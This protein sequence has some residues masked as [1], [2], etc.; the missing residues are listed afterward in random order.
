MNGAIAELWANAINAAS[1]NKVTITGTSHQRLLQT[2]ETNSPAIP[3]LRA[4]LRMNF[5]GLVHDC[6]RYRD[7]NCALLYVARQ[8]RQQRNFL[9]G[10]NDSAR[11][12]A[13]QPPRNIVTTPANRTVFRRDQEVSGIGPSRPIDQLI[14]FNASSIQE[15]NVLPRPYTFAAGNHES[16]HR[17]SGYMNED[18]PE[19]VDSFAQHRIRRSE[20]TLDKSRPNKRHR[21]AA[22]Q[23]RVSREHG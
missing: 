1:R 11:W 19:P 5:I 3:K 9:A 14:L 16:G 17:A 20:N 23:D 21:D 12:K 10:S 7:A 4:A 13:E 8:Y 22:Q 18:K 2:K 15:W 6:S